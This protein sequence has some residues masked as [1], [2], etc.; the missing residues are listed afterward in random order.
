MINKKIYFFGLIAILMMTPIMVLGWTGD[1][2]RPAPE[3]KGQRGLVVSDDST[4]APPPSTPVAR[5]VENPQPSPPSPRAGNVNAPL[6]ATQPAQTI[7]GFPKFLRLFPSWSDRKPASS[8]VTNALGIAVPG[9]GILQVQAES[10]PE[11]PIERKEKVGGP[12]ANV[13][14]PTPTPSANPQDLFSS[15]AGSQGVEIQR[16]SPLVG[17]PR[18]EGLHFG[19]IVT[20]A[21]GAYWFPARVDL[22]TVISKLNADNIRDIVVIRG[23]YSVRHGP[24]FSFLDIE[25]TPTFR[26]KSGCFEAYGS[27]A[28]VY[29]TNGDGWQGTQNLWGGNA[30]WGFRLSY[31]LLSAGDYAAGNGTR[32]PST[33]NNHFV[34]FAFGIDLSPTSQFEIKYVHV[35]QSNVL[36]PGL[37]TGINR[38]T[39]DAVNARFEATKGDWYDRFVFDA[40]MNTTQFNGDSANSA[41]RRQIPILDNIFTT[42]SI[43]DAKG[44]VRTNFFPVRLDINTDGNAVAFG[45]REITTWGALDG[46]NVSLGADVRVFA[47]YYNELDAFNISLLQPNAQPANLGIPNARQIDTGILLDSSIPVGERYLFKV[48]AR[49]DMVN[50]RFIEFGRNVDTADYLARVGDTQG[51]KNFFLYS[52]YA[53]GEYKVT[54]DWS[55]QSSYGYAQRP[56]TLTE[57]YAGGAFLGMIQNGLNSIYG[58]PELNKEQIHQINLGTTANYE[59]FR[60]GFNAYYAFLPDYI[61][62]DS[63]GAFTVDTK[64]NGAG[65]GFVGTTPINRLR[66]VNTRLATLYGFDFFS[67]AK[68]APWLTPFASLSFVEGWDQSRDTALPGIAPLSARLGL[69]VHEPETKPRWAVEYFARVVAD[70][71]LFA[72]STVDPRLALGE[73]R[74]GGFV[75]HNLRGYWNVSE[76]VLVH[77]GLENFGNRNYREHLDLR[78]GFGVLQPGINFYVGMKMSY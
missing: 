73:Q 13:V 22:D 30:D 67:E 57:L 64:I 43:T 41:T 31:D 6:P 59:F 32:L 55:V 12:G 1:G 75:V 61:T 50:T 18:I 27:S 2:P 10:R 17:D 60:T 65:D 39:T 26:S 19:Q 36:L 9:T 23:P 42:A 68:V 45:A 51:D 33:Y 44:N 38:L 8:D 15:A 24:G 53:M 40:W 49:I 14:Q 5:P 77:A 58:N 48:G 70:Q 28:V 52:G 4:P 66:F 78:T 34:D 16:R 25:T 76:K 35:L 7:G 37:L 21:D 29:R 74:T 20:Q 63:L 71:D 62:Y 56:P 3:P 72:N 54:P 46:F 47:N 69:R 11:E